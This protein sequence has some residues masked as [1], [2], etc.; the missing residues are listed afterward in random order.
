MLVVAHPRLSV[1]SAFASADG[2]EGTMSVTDV[3][4]PASPEVD[5]ASFFPAMVSAGSASDAGG[6]GGS[7]AVPML[8]M[9]S[10]R[11][12]S[13]TSASQALPATDGSQGGQNWPIVVADTKRSEV[14]ET[15]DADQP[16]MTFDFAVGGAAITSLY[17]SLRPVGSDENVM[18]AFGQ[19][20]LLN[21]NGVPIEETNPPPG[22]GP[23]ELEGLN[24]LLRS[25]T[26]G[27]RLQVQIVPGESSSGLPGTPSTSDSGTAAPASTPGR[28]STFR[29]FSAF[30]ARTTLS[31]PATRAG[32]RRVRYRSG[33][34]S[35]RRHPRAVRP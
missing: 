35:W 29:S 19:M 16:M 21:P 18:P 14:A 8:A 33:P 9:G 1:G 3:S 34:S 7:D 11:R 28:A 17:L 6:T 23:G 4:M 2:D 31:R 30:S 26:Y 20:E 10:G 25:A 5:Q 13:V 24:V 12:G 15:L 32:R 22:P 27:S